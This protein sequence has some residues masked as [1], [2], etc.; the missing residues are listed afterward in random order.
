MR[1]FKSLMT[2]ND[3]EA[4][5]VAGMGLVDDYGHNR[6]DGSIHWCASTEGISAAIGGSST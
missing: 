5:L 2:A 4:A 3:P 1:L 6:D